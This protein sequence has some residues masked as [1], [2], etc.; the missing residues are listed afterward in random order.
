MALPAG[1][2][3][4]DVV[5]TTA[6]GGYGA[7]MKTELLN[8]SDI[9]TST[10]A[11]DGV[12]CVR[13]NYRADADGQTLSDIAIYCPQGTELWKIY[14]DYNNGDPAATAHLAVF[15]TILASMKLTAPK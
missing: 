4:L 15:N 6:Y 5:T 12:N 2:A 7:I 11:V 10:V 1:G 8:T 3:E 9:S 13:A 14:F